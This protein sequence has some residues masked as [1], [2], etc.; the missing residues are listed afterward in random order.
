MII[1]KKRLPVIMIA[2]ACIISLTAMFIPITVSADNDKSIIL[3]CT[4]DG[5]VLDGMEWK[6]YRV[7]QRDG[8]D[9]VLTGDFA[10]Y[11]VDIKDMSA[12]NIIAQ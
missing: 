8:G 4:K 5:T 9:F 10:S 2:M 12:E 1:S 11:P 7:G 6:I 3:N